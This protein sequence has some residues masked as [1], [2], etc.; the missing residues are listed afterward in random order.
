[1][2]QEEV[3]EIRDFPDYVIGKSGQVY[4]AY[5][6][7][8][9]RSSLTR[10]GAVKITLFRDGKPYTRSL[11]RIVAEHW[12]YNDYDPEIF[13][14]PIHLDN[15]LQNNHVDNLAWRPRWF[16]VQYQQQYWNLE[17]RNSSV[18]V[19]D[20]KAEEV[21]PSIMAVCQKHGLLFVDVFKSCTKG[22]M[23]FPTWKTFRFVDTW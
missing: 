2:E 21:W 13:D 4:T 1:M 22:D 5:R 9:R 11:A 6:L 8:P 18:P 17:F 14:T 10:H 3:R 20:V 15:D 23:V 12:L 7:R 19:V 16:A